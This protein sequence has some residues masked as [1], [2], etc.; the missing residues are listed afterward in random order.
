[1]I[2]NKFF[3]DQKENSILT[4]YN[5][6]RISNFIYAEEL[7]FEQYDLLKKENHIIVHN[8]HRIVYVNPKI[9]L[10]ENDVI[11]CNSHYVKYLF[12]D[13]KSCNLKNLK[14]IT[15]QSDIPINES[16][17][18]K[19]PDC[20]SNWY[21]INIEYQ[22][23]DLTPIPIGL[24]N[25]YSPKNL[26]YNHFKNKDLAV[27]KKLDVIY[28]NFNVSTNRK[29]R[30]KLLKSLQ[31]KESFYIEKENKDLNGYLNSLIKYK[32]VLCPEGNGIDT[33]RFWETIY[34]GSIPVSKKH[35]TLNT[36]QGLPVILIEDY[37][38]LSFEEILNKTPKK[39]DYE[40]EKLT[41]E[42]WDNLIN[43]KK[44][45][46]QET[47]NHYEKNLRTK[48]NIFNYKF[49]I[50]SYSYYKK[51]KFYFLKLKNLS[52]VIKK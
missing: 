26:F 37:K 21:G 9:K 11:F 28:V 29:V 50:Y 2:S 34:S 15:H 47:F 12:R 35:T 38:N 20:I 14:L 44:I 27:S 41:V 51:V 23:Y 31:N 36:S 17:Y 25:Y 22:A 13:L 45:D 32:Y 30:A 49:K 19:K 1:M 3:Q 7:T 16:L 18:S 33:H 39:T 42:Y 10:K 4:S 46:S 52:K 43:S 5:F 48:A 8:D 6:A 24:S 40:F